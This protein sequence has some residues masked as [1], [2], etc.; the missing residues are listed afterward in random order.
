MKK[1]HVFWFDNFDFRYRGIM[2]SFDKD[3]FTQFN[4]TGEAVRPYKGL[5]VPNLKVEYKNLAVVPAMPDRPFDMMDQVKL[6][7]KEI[8]SRGEFYYDESL[9]KR[10]NVTRIPLKLVVDEQKNQIWFK[11]LAASVD[12]LRHLRPKGI[13]DI[14]I[15]TNDALM[16]YFMELRDYQTSKNITN[17]SKYYIFS[18]DMNIYQRINKVC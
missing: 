7:L 14:P 12:G 17:R 11:T 10:F 5:N 9:V 13:R 18:T 16:K 8:V 1:P 2:P 4:W 3:T 6:C 15:G